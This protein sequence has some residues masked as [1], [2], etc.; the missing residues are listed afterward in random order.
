[1]VFARNETQE[2]VADTLGRLLRER[3]DFNDRRERLGRT[4]PERLALWP[5]LIETGM[6][7][8][9]FPE[10]AGGF[11]GSGRDVAVLAEALGRSLVVEPVIAS[12]ISGRVL[13]AEGSDASL[14]MIGEIVA[15]ERIL[16]LAH[17]EGYDPFAAPGARAEQEGDGYRLTGVKPLV[18][19]ADVATSFLVTAS[20]PGEGW[21][22]FLVEGGAAGLSLEPCRLMDASG[23]ATLTLANAVATP[24]LLGEAARLAVQ[25][26]VEWGLLAMSAEGVGI[27]DALN[28][29]TREYLRTR[30]QFGVPI[31]SFQALQHRSADMFIAAQEAGAA[32]DAVI[33]SFGTDSP[34]QDNAERSARVSALKLLLDGAGRKVGFEAIQL[35][36]GVGVSDE[37]IV[38]HH[39]RRLT[40]IRALTGSPEAHRS[41]YAAGG[42]VALIEEAADVAAFRAELRDFIGA[43]LPADIAEASARGLELGREDF[44]RWERVLRQKGWFAAAWPTA[45]GGAGWDLGRQLT[46]VQESGI[47]GAPVLKPYGVNMLG[48]VLQHFGT[49]AQKDR[50]LPDILDSKTWWCQGYSEPNSGSDLA[51]LKTFAVR[52]GD[53]Y[54]VNGTKM[55]TTEAQWANMMHAL[56]RTSRD[57]KPQQ[58]ISFLLIDMTTPGISIQPIVTLD[59]QYHTNQTFFDNVRVPVENLVGEEGGGWT[60]AK[61]LLANERI[62][63]ADTGPKLRLL[64]QLKA[65]L[66]AIEHDPRVPVAEYL[67]LKS[68]TV[69]LDIQLQVLV[70]LERRYVD[71]WQ[72]GAPVAGPEASLLKIRGTEILQALAE[73]AIELRGSWGAVHDPASLHA[74][75]GSPASPVEAASALAHEFLYSRCWSIFGGSNEIQRNIIAGSIAG[76]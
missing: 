40:T 65:L 72:G 76:R 35:H 6:I 50:Y 15:G 56:V 12:L 7:G 9:L 44:L 57:G 73:L 68:R 58:G 31:G 26:A 39:M 21:G 3:Y 37:L 16:V 20:L 11:G 67:R 48:P 64:A 19:N 22:C 28:E 41:R 36:G 30:V 47:V 66:A 5:D 63:I 18:A 34:V 60:I 29:Q 75:P 4:P 55:W 17:D 69:D 14:A 43:N 52:E 2:M 59:G 61:F 10:S 1:M 24:L 23:A 27:L 51:S 74:K 42:T 54:V 53:H 49:Q 71:A 62:S 13:L 38:S 45:Y 8:A 32:V 25:D 46:F 33:E 70:T